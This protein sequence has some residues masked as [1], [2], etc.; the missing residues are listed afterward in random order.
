MSMNNPEIIEPEVWGE[1]YLVKIYW[2]EVL[3]IPGHVGAYETHRNRR[4]TPWNTMLGAEC[5]EDEA[6]AFQSWCS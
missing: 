3:K 5:L 6:G 2:L 1:L 4:N